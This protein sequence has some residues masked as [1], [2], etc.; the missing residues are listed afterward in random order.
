M[1]QTLYIRHASGKFMGVHENNL[2][3]VDDPTPDDRFIYTKN[4]LFHNKSKKY[5]GY[6]S[7]MH[8]ILTRHPIKVFYKDAYLYFIHRQIKYYITVRYDGF[9]ILS[10]S[11]LDNTFNTFTFLSNIHFDETAS[12][13]LLFPEGF[14]KH[15]QSG[16]FVNKK[17][18]SYRYHELTFQ[19]RNDVTPTGT[20]YFTLDKDGK[21]HDLQNDMYVSVVSGIL[22][23][24]K[25]NTNKGDTFS[26]YSNGY[27]KHTDS[28]MFVSKIG[29]QLILSNSTTDTFSFDKRNYNYDCHSC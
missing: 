18:S 2:V 26:F 20:S 19:D 15:N 28:G 12:G 8:I 14:L 7:N 16:L 22:V 4:Y 23:E 10:I 27:L 6:N 5:V 17:N 24:S 3:L 11:G 29:S 21:L 25:C 9:F 13:K 1:T